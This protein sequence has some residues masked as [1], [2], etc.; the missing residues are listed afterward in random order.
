MNLN[1]IELNYW[2]FIKFLFYKIKTNQWNRQSENG[3]W[4]EK[5]ELNEYGMNE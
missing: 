1:W 2:Y 4:I 3:V 5:K